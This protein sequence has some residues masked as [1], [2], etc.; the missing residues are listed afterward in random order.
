MLES[1]VY[2]L[3]IYVLIYMGGFVISILLLNLLGISNGQ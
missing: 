1:I 3:E 2:W